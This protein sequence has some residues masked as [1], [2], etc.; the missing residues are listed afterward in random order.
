LPIP[1]IAKQGGDFWLQLQRGS[2]YLLTASVLNPVIL[3]ALLYSVWL[4]WQSLRQNTQPVLL[5]ITLCSFGAYSGFVWA[6]GGDW[7]QAG[8]FVAPL[9]VP[10]CL[11]LLYGLKKI[12]RRW[13]AHASIVLLVCL[14]FSI[15]YPVVATASHG[16]PAWVQSQMLPEHAARYS[17]FEQLNQEHVRD[18][19]IIDHIAELIPPL[20]EKLARPVLLMSGQAGMVFYY[21]ATQFYGQVQFRDLR[22]LVESSLTLCP[23]LK[24]IPRSPQGLNWGYS[25][26]FAQL[27]MLE[28]QCAIKPPDIIYDLN[29]MDQKLGKTL[30]PL[31]YT[32]IHQETG[33]PV[34]NKTGLPYNRLLAPNMIFVRNDLLPLIG[35]PQ[36]RIINY[37]ELP[38]QTRW[39]MPNNTTEH[40]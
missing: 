24:N 16:I 5:I 11:L 18:M 7:M 8:R 31:G 21:T 35:N 40:P 32:M 2:F 3:L 37:R 27:P 12:T 4:G 20:H 28:Q 10:G 26:F 9:V 29:G 33:F 1:A 25:D 15:Q 17:V 23:A 13:F 30:E 22:G 36:K 38:L 19:A 34:V 14:Q 6:A 39:P